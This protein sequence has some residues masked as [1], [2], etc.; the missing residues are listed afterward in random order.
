MQH[1]FPEGGAV[2]S[3]RSCRLGL[4]L[5]AA[6][7]AATAVAPPGAVAQSPVAGSFTVTD[8]RFVSSKDGSTLL[9][10]YSGQSVEFTYP[11]GTNPHNV[12]FLALKP[13]SCTQT[14]GPDLGPVP[15]LPRVPTGPGW[16]GTCR[17]TV[18]QMYAF[19]SRGPRAMA[20]GVVVRPGSP[21]PFPTS[22]MTSP[23][24]P[25]G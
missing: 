3:M 9:T 24:A 25:R 7:A 20:G 6:S 16:S 19:V 1:P 13:A 14:A 18:P 15:P 12:D 23:F 5:A 2:K 17:F 21:P 10:I 4:A 11:V 22:P 8:T